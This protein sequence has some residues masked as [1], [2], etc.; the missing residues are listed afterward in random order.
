M[1][2][3]QTAVS[4]IDIHLI[5]LLGIMVATGLLGGLANFFLNERDTLCADELQRW[6]DRSARDGAQSSDL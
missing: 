3:A 4:G 2:G 1:G 6:P 5:L